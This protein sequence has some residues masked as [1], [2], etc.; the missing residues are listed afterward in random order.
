MADFSALISYAVVAFASL[1]ILVDP[2]AP[3]AAVPV[4][5]VHHRAPPGDMMMSRLKAT[6]KGPARPG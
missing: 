4:Q 6:R 2:L 3:Q 5:T 1:F